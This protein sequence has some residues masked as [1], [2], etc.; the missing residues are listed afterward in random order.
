MHFKYCYTLS[1]IIFLAFSAC[2]PQPDPQDILAE[3]IQAVEN[4][5]RPSVVTL[6][7]SAKSFSIME[8]MEHYNV[9]G[10]SIAVV[11]EGKLRWAKGYGTANTQTRS[12]VD[13]STL[14]Q[15]GSIS[16]P[17]AALAVLKLAE[18]G[19]LELDTD[20]NTY[21]TDWK[22]ENSK[23]TE[24]EK[25]TLRGLLTHSAGVTVHG[26]PGYI[27]TDTF[28]SVIEVLDGEGNTSKIE[29]DTVPGSIWRYSGGGYTIAQKA[30]ADVSGMAFAEYLDNKILDPLGM[31][32]STY[33]QPLPEQYHQRASAAYDEQGN[34]IEGLWHNYPELAAAGLWTTPTDLAKYCIAMQEIAAGQPSDILSRATVEKMLTKHQNN[35]GLGPGLR[36]EGDSLMFGHGGKNAGFTNDM[37]ASV[38]HGNAVIIM[39]NADNG[40]PLIGEIYRSLV[41][42]YDINQKISDTRVVETVDLSDEQLQS[43]AG[44][45]HSTQPLFGV[46]NYPINAHAKDGMLILLD[47]DDGERFDLTPLPD[48]T[49]LDFRRNTEVVFHTKDDSLIMTLKNY[50][51]SF[52]RVDDEL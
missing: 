9:P 37:V 14:F 18:E 33:E 23:Y 49:F 50:N 29:V 16:K 6:A 4:G 10:V 52:Y 31:T 21:L 32:N 41:K 36:G 1:L 38:R 22:I 34:L 27:Q 26:F 42:Q 35:W 2:S 46:T 13:E 24:D 8:R 45:Y 7:D 12:P 47:P 40:G 5:L 28:P 39:T 17:V 20:V 3:E 44:T 30:V 25:V 19:K 51:F 43:F 15:A 48:S 11:T